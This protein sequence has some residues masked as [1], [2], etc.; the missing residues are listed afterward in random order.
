[1]V[2]MR[3]VS[4]VDAMINR[5]D[6]CHLAMGRNEKICIGVVMIHIDETNAPET[7]TTIT[8]RKIKDKSNNRILLLAPNL[9]PITGPSRAH[10]PRP[11]RDTTTRT[12][13]TT[14]TGAIA[15]RRLRPTPPRT[16]SPSARDACCAPT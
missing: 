2:M 12:T 5:E 14:T 6:R 7:P 16:N 13:T 4:V 9:V 1:M 3:R 11:R 8:D 15:P 10:L